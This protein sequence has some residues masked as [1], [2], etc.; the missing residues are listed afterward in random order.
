MLLNYCTSPK[1]QCMMLLPTINSNIL[2][3]LRQEREHSS[4][5]DPHSTLPS[6]PS[7]SNPHNDRQHNLHPSPPL[8]RNSLVTS[9]SAPDVFTSSPYVHGDEGA[10][11]SV[12]L[13]QSMSVDHMDPGFIMQQLHP[14]LGNTGCIRNPQDAPMVVR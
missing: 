1:W 9:I 14:A 13:P 4:L 7:Y 10:L 2:L 12:S 6:V 11:S 5:S 8:T 3:P